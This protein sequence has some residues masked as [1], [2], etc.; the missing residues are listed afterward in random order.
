MRMSTGSRF[1]TYAPRFLD[2]SERDTHRLFQDHRRSFALAACGCQG[3]DALF[4]QAI[5][6][7]PASACGD[8]PARDV[9]AREARP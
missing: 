5:G 1:D 6:L 7:L 3:S 9:L 8:D 4:A 2:P